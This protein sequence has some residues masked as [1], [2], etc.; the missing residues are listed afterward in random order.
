M[1]MNMNNYEDTL[2]NIDVISLTDEDVLQD[3]IGK[4]IPKVKIKSTLKELL[5]TSKPY[6]T[7]YNGFSFKW[8]PTIEQYCETNFICNNGKR[9][10]N[11]Y[12]CLSITEDEDTITVN[13]GFLSPV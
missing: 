2:L 10:A 6:F 11:H 3:L 12:L 8:N 4:T 13:D 5:K 1:D 9:N 7:T